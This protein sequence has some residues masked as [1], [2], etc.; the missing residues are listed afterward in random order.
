MKKLL[1]GLLCFIAFNTYAQDTVKK[2]NSI[3][4]F[5]EQFM[6]LKSDKKIRQGSYQLIID[7]KTVASG[8]YDKGQRVGVW[9]FYNDDVLQQQYDYSAK[10]L[11]MN[12]SIAAIHTEVENAAE[13]DSVKEAVKIGGFNG[14][15]LLVAST[16][17]EQAI[18]GSGNNKVSHALTIDENG[19]IK[20]WIA[21]VKNDDGIKVV[22][23]KIVDVPAEILAFLP[24]TVNGKAV[25][26]TV[27][28]NADMKGS[29]PGAGG[30]AGDG[31]AKMRGGGG[32]GGGRRG[33]G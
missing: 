9:N 20:S 27:T 10:K 19:E 15:K 21:T 26:S 33:R 22:T 2:S 29:G 17:F 4:K 25:T 8:Q 30:D 28:F 23:Q 12:K 11:V 6:V 1:L 7:K 18:S 5:N 14:F 3:G 32:G 13:T 16:D 31:R 24:A